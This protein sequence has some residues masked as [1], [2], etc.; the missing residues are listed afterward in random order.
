MRILS[1]VY[2]P[3][4][5]SLRG[6]AM[7]WRIINLRDLMEKNGHEVD[8]VCFCS[9]FYNKIIQESDLPNIITNLNFSP[10]LKYFKYIYTK[11]YDLIFANTTWSGFNSLLGKFNK[12]PPVFVDVHGLLAEEYMLSHS[13]TS[14]D[15]IISFRARKFIDSFSFKHSDKLICVSKNLIRY[16]NSEKNIPLEK[17][18]YIPNGVNINYF[19]PLSPESTY[20]V[21]KRLGI[22][23]KV[24]FGYLGEFQKWQGVENFINAAREI[25]DKELAFIVVGGD[26]TRKKNNGIIFIPRVARSLLI[27]YYSACDVLVLP[28]PNHIATEIAAPTKFAEYASMAKPILTTDVGDA[29]ELVRK[30]ECGIV[31][32]SNSIDDM[33]GGIRAFKDKT[34]GQME[35]MGRNSRKLVEDEFEWSHLRS[36]IELALGV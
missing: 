34:E 30:Y 33:I 5:S 10:N 35:R 7:L 18:C 8:L 26:G 28:R 20:E 23:D 3:P 11:K 12:H 22:E 25:D 32:K 27:N 2:L 24:T 4:A 13:L 9:K 14:I 6:D 31:I 29:A 19:K 15:K 17:M 21:K 36:D 16:L 1:T